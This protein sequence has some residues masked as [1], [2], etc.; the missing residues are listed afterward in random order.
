M[1]VSE[2]TRAQGWRT[3]EQYRKCGK[4]RLRKRE[5]IIRNN[6]IAGVL[7]KIDTA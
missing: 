1:V 5:L 2:I 6:Q 3:Q 7:E 4:A